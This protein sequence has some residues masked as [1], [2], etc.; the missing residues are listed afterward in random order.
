[1]N[2]E[3]R[4]VTKIPVS[5]LQI[6]MYVAELDKDWLDSPFLYQ[7][8]MIE[9]QEDIRLLEEECEYVWIE[10]AREARR[11]KEWALSVS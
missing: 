5:G 1:M 3:N 2:L 9:S 8:F 11:D 4:K 10:P 6:G 7:G